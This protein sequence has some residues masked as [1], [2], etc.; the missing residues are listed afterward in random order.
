M[1]VQAWLCFSVGIVKP[2]TVQLGVIW[3]VMGGSPPRRGGLLGRAPLP[4]SLGICITVKPAAMGIPGLQEKLG[5]LFKY[6]FL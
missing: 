6:A 1:A 5:L 2:Q 4:A 3:Q